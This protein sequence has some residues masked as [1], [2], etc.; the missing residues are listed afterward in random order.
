MLVLKKESRY[1]KCIA[2]M[3]FVCPILAY[4]SACWDPSR[5]QINALDPV[6]QKAAQFTNH[7]KDIY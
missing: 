1:T 5:G 4:G 7:T 3:S 6:P 2:F